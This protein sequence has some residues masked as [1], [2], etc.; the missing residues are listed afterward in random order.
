MQTFDHRTETPV[1]AATDEEKEEIAKARKKFNEEMAAF[2]EL[3]NYN[4]DV[5]Y[6]IDSSEDFKE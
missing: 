1:P 6:G 3:M 2:Q 5:A 4:A